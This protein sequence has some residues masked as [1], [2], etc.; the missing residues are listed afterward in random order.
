MIAFMNQ[1]IL[2]FLKSSIPKY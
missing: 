1:K 2:T